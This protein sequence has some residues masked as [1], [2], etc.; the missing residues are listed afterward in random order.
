MS[1]YLL[2]VRL[3]GIDSSKTVLTF[4][5]SVDYSFFHSIQ[6]SFNCAFLSETNKNYSTVILIL[7]EFASFEGLAI[8]HPIPVA[9]AREKKSK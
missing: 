5:W 8:G 2:A 9:I 4:Y 6:Y 7:H 1:E 3:G